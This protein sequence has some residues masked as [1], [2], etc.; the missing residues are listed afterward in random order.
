MDVAYQQKINY[1][2]FYALQRQRES[3]FRA[4]QKKPTQ[5]PCF[6]AKCKSRIVYKKDCT[7]CVCDSGVAASRLRLSSFIF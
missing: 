5:G 6:F 1:Y 4:E 2:V 3:V 7:F